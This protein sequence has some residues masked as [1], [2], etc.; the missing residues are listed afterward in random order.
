M[1]SFKDL[2][3]QSKPFILSKSNLLPTLG[4]QQS[5]SGVLRKTYL[6]MRAL[7]QAK[8]SYGFTTVVIIRSSVRTLTVKV[9]LEL[10][11]GAL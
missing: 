9:K 2:R 7:D 5:A 8:R 6:S 11:H 10:G 4:R 3:I 1:Q